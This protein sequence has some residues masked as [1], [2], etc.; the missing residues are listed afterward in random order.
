[1]GRRSLC[2]GRRV[3]PAKSAGWRRVRRSEC[4]RKSRLAPFEMMVA[5]WVHLGR[6]LGGT[7]EGAE[8]GFIAV[9]L[10]A[11][12]HAGAGDGMGLRTDGAIGVLP[13]GPGGPIGGHD[14]GRSIL[15]QPEPAIG[16]DRGG[17]RAE[18]ILNIVAGIE[19]R[20]STGLVVHV[21]DESTGLLE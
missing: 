7:P 20:V 1:M 3:H 21:S 5:G 10:V 9:E 2:A 4:G 12:A 18:Q 19:S 13:H 17:S 16:E 11:V 14:G 8:G 15:R 6:R